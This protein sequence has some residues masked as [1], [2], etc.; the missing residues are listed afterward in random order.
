MDDGE[1]RDRKRQRKT[2]RTR[3]R[4]K[5]LK[6]DAELDRPVSFYGRV[7]RSKANGR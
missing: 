6:R 1:E 7:F 4:A 5:T 2:I 3:T